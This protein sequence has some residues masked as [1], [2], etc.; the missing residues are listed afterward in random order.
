MSELYRS[1][2]FIFGELTLEGHRSLSPLPS[3][4]VARRS[5]GGRHDDERVCRRQK[6]S[7]EATAD[8]TSYTLRGTDAKLLR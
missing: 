7:R 1:S 4:S 5:H 3:A 8:C 6:V 2:F